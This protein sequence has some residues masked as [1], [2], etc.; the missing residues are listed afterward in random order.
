MTVSLRLRS[1]PSCGVSAS[2]LACLRGAL[3]RR[4]GL[5][6]DGVAAIEPGRWAGPRRLLFADGTR[7]TPEEAAD[8]ALSLGSVALA[9]VP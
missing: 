5:S 8:P 7:L 4:A 3:V 9:G 6:A 1:E 2:G